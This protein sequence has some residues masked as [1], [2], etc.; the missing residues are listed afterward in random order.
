MSPSSG[1]PL[2]DIPIRHLDKLVHF[3]LFFIHAMLLA[4]ALEV[5]KEA[6]KIFSFGVILTLATE[7]LQTY[8]PG[9][10]ADVWDGMADVCGTSSGMLFV[11]LLQYQS[12]K[13]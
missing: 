6:L 5:K 12:V 8:V 7:G 1:E 13:K 2:F 11:Y 4:L 3:G 10:Q 9:R